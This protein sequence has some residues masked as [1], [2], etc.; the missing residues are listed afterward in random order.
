MLDIIKKSIF[1]GLGIAAVTKEKVE[2]FVDELIEKGQLAKEDKIIVV[3]EIVNKIEK[4]ENE[5]VND[6][7][8]RVLSSFGLAT[9][10]DI[11]ELQE[12]ISKLEKKLAYNDLK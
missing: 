12:S 3:Q 5:V 7:L 1:L 2:S 11:K 10:K 6:A 4:N 9:Q 8:N